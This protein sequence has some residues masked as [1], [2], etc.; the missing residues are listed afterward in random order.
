MIYSS[1]SV[2][3]KIFE[4]NKLNNDLNI[5]ESIYFITRKRFDEFRM[6]LCKS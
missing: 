4:I 5:V 2:D 1:H 6:E 3:R